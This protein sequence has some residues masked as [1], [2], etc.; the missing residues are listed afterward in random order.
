MIIWKIKGIVNF[1]NNNVKIFNRWGNLIYETSN[2][3]EES[4][5]WDGTINRGLSLGKKVP[6]GSYFFILEIKESAQVITGYIVVNYNN[7]Y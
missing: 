1:P 2:Y 7:Q 3:D 5:M 4:N 6:S